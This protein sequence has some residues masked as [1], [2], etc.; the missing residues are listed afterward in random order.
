MLIHSVPDSASP[1]F[2]QSLIQASI[3]HILGSAQGFCY[4]CACEGGHFSG[5]TPDPSYTKEL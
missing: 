2:F 4:L 1:P 5:P 3:S